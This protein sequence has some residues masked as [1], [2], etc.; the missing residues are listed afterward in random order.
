MRTI[1]RFGPPLALMAVIFA[2]SAQADLGTGLGAWDTVLRKAAHMAEYGLLWLLWWR[3]FEYR[4]PAAAVAITFAYA[5]SDEWH[6]TFVSG[7][8]GTPWDVAIDM[9]GVAIAGLVV[10]IAERRRRRAG[11]GGRRDR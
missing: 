2:F 1:S 3:A 6:Q 7:R 11:S 9:A 5:V 10:V 4:R 8:H